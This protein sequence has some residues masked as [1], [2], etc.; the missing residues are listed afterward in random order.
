MR[1]AGRGA[2]VGEKRAA[3]KVTILAE[4]IKRENKTEIEEERRNVNDA[5]KI[6]TAFNA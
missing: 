5:K 6:R 1:W 3:L 2:R 4:E